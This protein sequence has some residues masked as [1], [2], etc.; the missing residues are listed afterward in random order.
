MKCGH[1]LDIFGDHALSCKASRQCIARHNTLVNRLV[2]VMRQGKISVQ[3]EVAAE[4]GRPDDI[5]AH[6]WTEGISAFFNITVVSP[7]CRTYI[8]AA[9]EPFGA[10]TKRVNEKLRKYEKNNLLFQPLVV[11]TLGAW[12]PSTISTFKTVA[13][14]QSE[15]TFQDTRISVA[16]LMKSLS[17]RLQ[18]SNAAM[19]SARYTF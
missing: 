8:S 14:R 13:A 3:Q 1:D 11:E 19:L 15:S 6:D 10:A 17:F 16:N 7:T 2:E 4:T 5:V 12:H 18:R 9:L